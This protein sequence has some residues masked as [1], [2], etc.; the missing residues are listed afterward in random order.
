M[1]VRVLLALFVVLAG[2]CSARIDVTIPPPPVAERVRL[3]A[4]YL[5]EHVDANGRF[6]YL[7]H[8][9]GLPTPQEYSMARHAGALYTIAFYALETGD[10]DVLPAL[11]RGLDYVRKNHVRTFGAHRELSA[12]FPDPGEEDTFWKKQP[13]QGDSIAKLGTSALM[14]AA[15]ALTRRVDPDSA[16]LDEM[17][18]FARFILYMQYLS[19]RFSDRYRDGERDDVTYSIYSPSQSTYA[20]ALLFAVDP[21][22]DWLDAAARGALYLVESQRAMR[23]QPTDH[24]L[25][26][27]YEAMAP[28]F[29]RL[30]DGDEVRTT[31]LD[32]CARIAEAMAQDQRLAGKTVT[33][34]GAFD[35][36]GNSCG[37]S[38]RLEGL[39]GLRLAL[40]PGRSG[41]ARTLDRV[42]AP[43]LSF[44]CRCQLTDGPLKGGFIFSRQ[45]APAGLSAEQVDEFKRCRREIR[46]DYVAHPIGALLRYQKT[47][48]PAG[49]APV[50]R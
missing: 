41:L 26:M 3:A 4:H 8:A 6:A 38:A 18:R 14:L 30:E 25:L 23:E 17:R 39:L 28:C 22:L 37:T 44:V 43:A 34:F 7:V 46:I 24:W 9:D 36:D 42:I 27:T 31:L 49:A 1:R 35:I 33:P 47:L 5:A 15:L 16:P 19:G 13:A 21:D 11:R 2:A 29:S 40:P 20:L 45:P 10:R 32:H 12:V 48:A 50:R